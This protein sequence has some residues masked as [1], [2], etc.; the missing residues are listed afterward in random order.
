L[1][2]GGIADSIILTGVSEVTSCSWRAVPLKWE[3]SIC[4]QCLHQ[5]MLSTKQIPFPTILHCDFKFALSVGVSP[6]EMNV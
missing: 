6:T 1:A 2:F 5:K 4:I 3:Q